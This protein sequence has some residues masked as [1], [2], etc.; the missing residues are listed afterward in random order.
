[1]R[2]CDPRHFEHT[3]DG[4]G[5]KPPRVAYALHSVL[6]WHGSGCGSQAEAVLNIHFHELEGSQHSRYHSVKEFI[7][8]ES[9]RNGAPPIMLQ[10]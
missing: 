10:L 8:G 2:V 5:I 4:E 7:T 6:V 9:L 1:M 3:E